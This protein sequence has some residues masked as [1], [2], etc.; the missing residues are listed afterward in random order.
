MASSLDWIADPA[1]AWGLRTCDY[2]STNRLLRTPLEPL[3]V[4]PPA[5]DSPSC[6][7][8]GRGRPIGARDQNSLDAGVPHLRDR[9]SKISPW[10]FPLVPRHSGAT[11][12]YEPLMGS[13]HQCA[14][15]AHRAV[16]ASPTGGL[17]PALTALPVPDSQ[18]RPRGHPL[19][20]DVTQR[21]VIGYHETGV[22]S[23]R[24][25]GRRHFPS[26]AD[27]RRHGL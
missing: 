11:L 1:P 18:G 4:R 6:R 12:S 9:R 8:G 13:V 21:A 10:P 7:E 20:T 3:G 2:A 5:G 15:R 22:R 25:A 24:S 27:T 26:T 16:K 14:P 23:L 19:V 17:R